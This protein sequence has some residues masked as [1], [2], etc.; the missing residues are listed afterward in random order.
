VAEILKQNSIDVTLISMHTIKPFDVSC[1]QQIIAKQTTIVTVEEHNVIGGLGSAVAEVI[2][3]SGKG[4]NFKRIGVP[5]VFSHYVGS[6]NYIR[7]KFGISELNILKE[8]MEMIN[9]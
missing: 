5:D 1:V 8:I 2:A 6:H 4:V 9:K 3:E 7:E